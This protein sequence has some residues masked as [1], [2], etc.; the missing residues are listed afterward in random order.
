MKACLLSRTGAYHLVLAAGRSRTMSP[1]EARK[2]LLTFDAA[3]HYAET[4]AQAEATAPKGE[5]VA[6][7]EDDGRLTVFSSKLFNTLFLPDD[8][9]YLTTKEYAEKFG[10]TRSLVLRHCREQRIPGAIQKGS[11]WLIPEEA[12]YPQDGRVGRRI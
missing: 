2:F 3:D 7:I 5:V 6:Q 4:S 9:K 8:T 1:D 12:P 11:T 10:K